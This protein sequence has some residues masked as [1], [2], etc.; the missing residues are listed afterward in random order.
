MCPLPS[1][2]SLGRCGLA[3]V[4]AGEIA[5][6]L[7]HVPAQDR[8]Q[9]RID[10]RGV[11]ARHELHQRAHFVAHRYLREAQLARQRGQRA[12][13]LRIA[14]AVH[15]DD[16]DRPDAV[17][18]QR[19][20]I[21]PCRL[22]VERLHD[23]AMRADALVD[24]DDTLVEQRRQFDPAHEE[25]R[26]V[27]VGDAQRVGKSARD[28]ECRRLA[29]ALEQRV[30]G[31]G[32]PHLDRLDDAWRNRRARRKAQHLADA[33]HRGVA[34]AFRIFRQQLV[35]RQ[36]A[37]RPA[38]HDVGERAAA[39]DPELPAGGR[40]RRFGHRGGVFRVAVWAAARRCIEPGARGPVRPP[41]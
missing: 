26:P 7:P 18:A 4:A 17:G 8:R 36:R 41:L 22:E 35:R 38:R 5:F 12:L 34:V 32:R 23:V 15:Q 33:V 6:D 3:A 27:L 9:V 2:A 19:S 10:D 40:G 29:G 21:A 39:V 14:I 11:P 37:V 13:V 24:L 1:P 20:E 30:G 25:L 28:G 16:R 31:D